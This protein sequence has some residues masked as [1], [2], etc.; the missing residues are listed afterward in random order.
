M[1]SAVTSFFFVR[2][3]RCVVLIFHFSPLRKKFLVHF[4]IFYLFCSTS[5]VKKYISLRLTL[6][7]L[8]PSTS[9]VAAD[10]SAHVRVRHSEIYFLTSDVHQNKIGSKLDRTNESA[11]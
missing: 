9:L 2:I 8:F 1:V 4:T 3:P 5:L 10:V 6:L 7:C 11:G